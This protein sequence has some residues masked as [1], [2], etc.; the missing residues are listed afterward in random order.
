MEKSMTY[1]Y[2]LFDLDGTLT[3]S[4]EGITKSVAYALQSCGIK[5]TDLHEL[6]K[7]IGPP[8]I[9]SFQQFYGMNQEQAQ[10]AVFKYRERFSQ[11]G[12]FE[13][14]VYPGI[15]E[16]LTNLKQQGKHLLVATSKPT[17]FAEKILD[18]F[19][20]RQYFDFVAGSGLQGERP[21]KAAVISY[22]LEQQKISL[23]RQVIMVGDRQY[24]MVAAHQ[25]GIDSLGVLYGFGSQ[26]ELQAAG[27]NYLAADVTAA[28]KFLVL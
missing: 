7:F 26:V 16:L 17:V 15:P 6:D 27:A 23:L 5:V 24:D 1:Q 4:S 8:L 21:N 10:K 12:I 19:E 3:D 9:D 11:T 28:Q 13:N 25:L 20:L 14:R 22:A 18:H 2:I